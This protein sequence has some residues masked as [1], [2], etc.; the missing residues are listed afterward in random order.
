MIRPAVAIIG[1]GPSA[2]FTAEELLKSEIAVDL[3][4]RLPTPY[5]LVRGGVAPDHPK[6]KSIADR[7]QRISAHPNFRFFGNVEAGRAVSVAELASLYDGVVLACG[8]A[9][10]RGLGIPGEDLFGSQ[11]AGAF[12]AWYNGHPDFRDA[13]FRL[14]QES[15]VIVGHGNVALDVARILLTPVEK[16]RT[17]EIADH[18]ID[19]LSRSAVRRVYLVGRRG[20]AQANFTPFE[21][22]ELLDFVDCG[23][24]VDPTDLALDFECQ[25]E[26]ADPAAETRR[27]NVELFRAAAAKSRDGDAAGKVVQFV[28]HTSSVAM[29]GTTGVE[30]L[31]CARNRLHGPAGARVA[32]PTGE[33]TTIDCGL[34]IRSIGFRGVPIEDVPFDPRTGTVPNRAGRV[35]SGDRP[36]AGLYVAGW[37][38]R[39]ST[40]VIGTNRACGIETARAVIDD[41]RDRTSSRHDRSALADLLERRGIRFVR[42]SGWT[43]IDAAE[44]QRGAARGKPREKLTRW[45]ELLAAAEERVA[46]E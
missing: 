12:V 3:I 24:V 5:G 11:A 46:A 30:G 10:D 23:A 22:K 6:I 18:A 36:L 42:F 41:L 25:T 14:D 32:R 13:A 31:R 17:T 44:K 20:P 33:E 45:D 16:L 35:M 34:V 19:A 43:R 28:F 40:G 2:Y 1:S 21:L 7:F 4:E 37:L 38:K 39:G 9:A 27:K 15:A 29:I 8:A 26:L